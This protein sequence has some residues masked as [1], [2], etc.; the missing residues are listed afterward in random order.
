VAAHQVA[1][2]LATVVAVCSGLAIA[3]LVAGE[4]V[5]EAAVDLAG[6]GAEAAWEEVGWEVAA[7]V[8]AGVRLVAMVSAPSV[9]VVDHAVAD[10]AEAAEKAIVFHTPPSAWT[11]G[12][13]V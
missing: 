2:S 9:G 5:E 10:L 12:R 7:S 4:E 3:A 8:A 1:A 11:M 13:Q 6:L